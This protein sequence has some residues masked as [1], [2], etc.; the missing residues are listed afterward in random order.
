MLD[1]ID[2][3]IGLLEP[4]PQARRVDDS[5]SQ[6]NEW[7]PETLYVYPTAEQWV[8]VGTG[9]VDSIGEI[10]QRF[11]IRIVYTAPNYTEEPTG[12]RSREVTLALEA[13]VEQYLSAI[14]TRDGL[15][16]WDNLTTVVDHDFLRQ[17]AVRGISIV[18]S[19]YRLRSS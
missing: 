16:P 3:L 17:F 4:D 1:L 12:K 5:G 19:G 6:P 13:K 14:L 18:A 10:E 11:S 9:S 15:P 8:R 2:A 7:A